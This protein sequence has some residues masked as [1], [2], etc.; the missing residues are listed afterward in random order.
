MMSLFDR[1]AEL[2]KT[3]C[4]DKLVRVIE[5]DEYA[6]LLIT[7][8][9]ELEEV[10]KSFQAKEEQFMSMNR[11][12]VQLPYSRGV[13]DCCHLIKTFIS[14]FYRFAEGFSQQNNE[15]DD[16]L[17]KSL[18][19]MLV[20]SMNSTILQLLASNNLSQVVQIL[21]NLAYFE[22]ACGEFEQ[23]LTERK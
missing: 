13:P 3:Q 2:M 5:E 1:Y 16:L 21:V 23:I 11:L 4:G 15:M 22:Q 9:D 7:T 10:R 14:G 12:P 17:K 20:N 8:K 18:E 19:N 6:P